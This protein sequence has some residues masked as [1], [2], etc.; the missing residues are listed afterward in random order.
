MGP[1]RVRAVQLAMARRTQGEQR[2]VGLLADRPAIRQV[3]QGELDR[4]P[5]PVARCRSSHAASHRALRRAVRGFPLGVRRA[6]VAIAATVTCGMAWACTPPPPPLG[7][8][9]ASA[10]LNS[11][12]VADENG[13]GYSR[14]LFHYP[15]DPDGNRCDTRAEVLLR[16]TVA[17]VH[18]SE[19]DL[20]YKEWMAS[21][22]S[23]GQGRRQV[24]HRAHGRTGG[25]VLYACRRRGS[26]LDPR[27]CGE[28]PNS[29]RQVVPAPMRST[30][31]TAAMQFMPSW[32]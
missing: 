25:R 6:I 28:Q 5:A 8:L 29:V 19:N 1:C 22:R 15:A 30:L 27:C 14:E 20:A 2:V 12:P 18:Q 3:V 7:Q 9:D 16:D 10:V 4:R 26:G 23:T 11:I 32:M 24:A 21:R 17:R 31:L 13:V